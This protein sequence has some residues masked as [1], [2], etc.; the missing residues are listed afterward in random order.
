MGVCCSVRDTV[1]L[2]S[3]EASGETHVQ[4]K[5]MSSTRNC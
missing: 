2:W 1:K 3:D 4:R 5:E